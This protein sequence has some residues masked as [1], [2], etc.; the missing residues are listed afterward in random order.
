M[1]T[2]VANRP[3]GS[4][5]TSFSQTNEVRALWHLCLVNFRMVIN[6][7][8]TSLGL[9][10]TVR[11]SDQ[12]E[13][14]TGPGSQEEAVTLRWAGMGPSACRLGALTPSPNVDKNR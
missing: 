11:N 10:I 9:Q 13:S 14:L 1:P 6:N 4:N 8:A 12:T 2:A 7:P 5:S 3:Q